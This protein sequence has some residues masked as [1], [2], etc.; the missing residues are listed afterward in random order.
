MQVPFLDLKAQYSEIKAE[1]I[2]AIN[3]VCESQIF[4]LGPVVAGFEK[5]IA[6]Y[7]GCKDAIGVSSGT[8]ALLVSL[9]ALGIKAGDEVITSAFSFGATA[10]AIARTG[11]KPVF[12]DIDSDSFN[13]DPSRVEEKI[14]ARTRAIM[15]VHL[16][17]QVAQM[18]PIIEIAKRKTIAVVEDACQSVG[19]SQNGVKCGNFGDL[20]C[21]SFYPTKNLGGF[22]DGGLVTTND[23]TLAATVKILRDHGQDGRYSYKIIGGNFRLDAIQAAVLQVKLKYLDQ[24]SEKRKQNATLYDKLL[25][26]PAAGLGDRLQ[27]PKIAANNISTY[28]HYTIR[29][30]RRDRLREYLSKNNIATAVYY[31]SPLHL[32]DCFRQLGYKQGDLPV[33]EQACGQVLSLPMYPEL[34]QEQIEYVAKTVLKFYGSD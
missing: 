9:M 12:V 23:E 28:N 29:A 31:P 3:E 4:A 2:A 32:Q 25:G 20:G 15:P 34:A 27:T 10:E 13:I 6:S 14:T 16:F 21:F 8:D 7:C 19:A 17:G 5:Q 22:G 24:W 11:A 33:A 1:I 26:P 18:Q 30:A